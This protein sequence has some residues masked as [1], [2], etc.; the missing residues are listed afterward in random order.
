M[1]LRDTGVTPSIVR[2]DGD[3]RLAMA[4]GDGP[5]SVLDTRSQTFSLFPTPAGCAFADAHRATLLWN[6]RS[7]FGLA[8]G[9]T[10]E[11]ATGAQA[12]LA[13]TAP[14]GGEATIRGFSA[15]GDR[16]ARI[17]LDGYH[18][19]NAYGYVDRATGAQSYANVQ[20]G[21]DRDL[22]Q[23]GLVRPLCAGHL[24]PMVWGG[25]GLE[26]GE[27]VAAGRWTAAQTITD[28]LDDGW[29]GRV[30]IQRCGTTRA[31]TIRVC[32]TVICSEPVLD[33]R[34]VAW[35]EQRKVSPYASR[36][37]VR[38][39]RSGRVR[40]TPWSSPQSLPGRLILVDHRLYV[41]EAPPPSP[42]YELSDGRARL[43]R[44]PV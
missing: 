44:A 39:L 32:R 13:T 29:F 25:I 16:F 21:Q 5:V 11:I 1:R 38:Q 35:T 28:T 17:D 24:E 14:P 3:H 12:T 7:A 43:L 9:V 4:I 22:D 10:Y 26:A 20:F 40:R 31:R 37:V 30:Q 27:P 42:P 41:H 33:D 19:M 34:I 36:L 6:C 8:T 2:G 15:I 18:F 23:P